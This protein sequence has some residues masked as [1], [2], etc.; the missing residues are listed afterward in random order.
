M[1]HR[2][3]LT[4]EPEQ[5][6]YIKS[7]Q[8]KIQLADT[9]LCMDAGPK[10]AWKDMANI[11]LRPCAD[12]EVAQ[13]WVAMADGRIALEASPGT[14]KYSEPNDKMTI[15][16]WA[17]DLTEQCIDLQYLRATQNNPVGL[18]NCAGLQNS[19]AADKG[20]NWPLMNATM[21]MTFA[22]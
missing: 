19:G 3:S 2:Q 7:N 18:Y 5:T 4:S 13:K 10:S 21:A 14:R 12:T 22:A 8:T 20:I 11:Y 1:Q 17:D 9:T 6:W 15:M 16:S